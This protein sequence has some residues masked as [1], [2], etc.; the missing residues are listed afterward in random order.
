MDPVTGGG[1]DVKTKHF[2]QALGLMLEEPAS[3]I[4][5]CQLDVQ[6]WFHNPNG[7]VHGG[8]LYTLVDTGMGLALWSLLKPGEIC[9]TIEIKIN[10][11]RP[12]FKGRLTADSRVIQRGN[13]VAVIDS[14]VE[15]EQGKLMAVATGS[16]HIG[17]DRNRK[18]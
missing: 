5:R 1:N 16:F 15:N 13:T 7:V 18:E 8:V 2:V 10:Y 12:V 9:S 11:L 4:S 17:P 3:G 14:R 6:D